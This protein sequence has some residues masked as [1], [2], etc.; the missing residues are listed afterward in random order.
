[1]QLTGVKGLAKTGV[2]T[3]E[4]LSNLVKKLEEF[5]KH[6]KGSFD[7]FEHLAKNCESYCISFEKGLLDFTG[8]GDDA[9]RNMAYYSQLT[10]TFGKYLEDHKT[11]TDVL[12]ST[13]KEDN[14]RN[15]EK[16]II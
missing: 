1:M 10:T 15:T 7:Y 6:T 4:A 16:Y 3:E 11:L 5:R 8:G 13:I 14:L 2:L 9:L 12:R